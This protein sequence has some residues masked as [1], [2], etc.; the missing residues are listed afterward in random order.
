MTGF[1]FGRYF[2]LLSFLVC[3]KF[4]RDV[5]H[6][7]CECNRKIRTDIHLIAQLLCFSIESN[8]RT[9]TTSTSNACERMKMVKR[10]NKCDAKCVCEHITYELRFIWCDIFKMHFSRCWCLRSHNILWHIFFPPF[11]FFLFHILFLFNS[12]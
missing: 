10:K 7:S 1:F 2:W 12:H 11:H 3:L 5:V 8:S 9:T 4:G 6:V